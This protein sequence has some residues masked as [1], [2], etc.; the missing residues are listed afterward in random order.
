MNSI[1]CF[2]E[3]CGHPCISFDVLLSVRSISPNNLSIFRS[4][5]LLVNHELISDGNAPKLSAILE[6]LERLVVDHLSYL[7]KNISRKHESIVLR[8]AEINFSLVKII[9]LTDQD[10]FL[11]LNF[12]WASLLTCQKQLTE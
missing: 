5:K 8:S 11:S 4:I 6:E 12:R 9:F 2:K 10:H 7:I 3:L 1:L